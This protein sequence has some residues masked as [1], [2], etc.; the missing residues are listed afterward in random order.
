MRLVA[1]FG[2]PEEYLAAY[3]EEISVGGLFLKGA[4]VEGGAAMSECTL[5]VLIGGEE[6]AEENAKL[7]FVTP[8]IGVAVVFLAPPA[9]LDELAARLRE[10]EPEPEAGAGDGVQQ[11]SARQLLAQLSPSQ[12]MS[13]ALK[14]GRAERHH[15]LRDNNKV[16]HAYVLRNP[17]LGL[18]EVQAAAKL[19]SLS[20]EALKAIGDH[21][22]WGQNSV[23]CAALVRNPKTPMAIALRLLPRV[24]LND[25]RAIAKG[26]GRQQIVLAARKLLAAR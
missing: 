16:L 12:K 9:A 18:D 1:E 10:P 5:A 14:A 6:V 17:H 21:P 2:S 13:L 11:N 19:N 25:L 24:P 23:I 8:G 26:A 7:A 15:L 22:E 4:S 3:E 20:P